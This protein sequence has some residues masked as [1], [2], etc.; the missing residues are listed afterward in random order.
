MHKNC[1]LRFGGTPAQCTFTRKRYIMY[2][3]GQHSKL[4]F[5]NRSSTDNRRMYVPSVLTVLNIMAEAER[6]NVIEQQGQSST[7]NN[8]NISAFIYYPRHSALRTYK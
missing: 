6:T 7:H 3:V 2:N 4:H 8:T 5:I 1:S